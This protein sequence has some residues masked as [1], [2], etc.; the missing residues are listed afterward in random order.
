MFI[1]SH[2]HLHMLAWHDDKPIA[3]EDIIADAKRNDI[4][5]MLCVAVETAD[6]QAMKD[7]CLPYTDKIV[8]SAGIHPCYVEEDQNFTVL[9]AQAKD[10]RVVAIGE[11][12]LDY[13]YCQD[14]VIKQK[15]RHSFARQINLSARLDKPVIVHTRAARRD[16]IAVMQSENAERGRGVMH[17]FT[18]TIEMAKQALDL[19]FYIS[20]SGILTFKNAAQIREVC[21]YVPLERILIETDSPYLAPVPHRGKINRPYWVPCVAE[22]VA[23]IKNLTIE[24]V[25]SATSG[26]FYRLFKKAA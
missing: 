24:E 10:D 22:R 12:G 7:L 15:Q 8:L 9:E 16:T 5:K 14:E 20:F 17:C 18:E 1:D 23:E 26:N 21:R 2:C 4:E 19:G 25:A 6:W 3:I 13:F 11:T